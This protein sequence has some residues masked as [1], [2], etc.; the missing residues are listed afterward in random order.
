MMAQLRGDSQSR[1]RREGPVP[2]C[3]QQP[4]FENKHPIPTLPESRSLCWEEKPY[5]ISAL[6]VQK[7]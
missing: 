6:D 4:L 1:L 7:V 5:T 2:G 3:L